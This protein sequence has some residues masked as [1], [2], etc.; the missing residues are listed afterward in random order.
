MI[1][2]L[3]QIIPQN[4]RSLNITWESIKEQGNFLLKFKNEETRD[5]WSSCLQQ[6]IHDLKNEQFKARHHSTTS[7]TSTAKS[8]LLMSPTGTMT[9]PNHHNNRTHDSMASYSSSHMKRVS[10]VLPKRRT[11]SSS[12]ESE[13]KSISENF[14]NSIPE[15]SILLRISYNSTTNVN[16]SEIF[17]LLVEKVWNFDDLITAINSKISNTHSSSALP[18][19]KIKYQDEDGDFVILGSDEDWNVAKEM[20]AENNEKFLNIRLN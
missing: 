4:N 17:T 10:D 12:F 16:N 18:I 5:N 14:K 20:L 2:N 3:N 7:T 11:T 19:N 9:T 6:L 15:S 13:I 1:M 8:S